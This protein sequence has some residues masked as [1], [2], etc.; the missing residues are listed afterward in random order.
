MFFKH[1]L[2]EKNLIKEDE[3]TKYHK[4]IFRET[5]YGRLIFEYHAHPYDPDKDYPSE[6]AIDYPDNR[7]LYACYIRNH[8]LLFYYIDR[9][10]WYT[11]KNNYLTVMIFAGIVG[12]K[13]MNREI[14]DE[15]S[16]NLS[17]CSIET[18]SYLLENHE[19]YGLSLQTAINSFASNFDYSMVLYL[20]SKGYT[21]QWTEAA[22]NMPTGHII[23]KK[24]IKF[25]EYTN[26]I[27]REISQ[28]IRPNGYC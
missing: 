6:P 12:L 21:V 26:R 18:I 24:G 2:Y 22:W 17:G 3:Q 5:F 28:G 9:S 11:L 10:E 23:S 27:S 13:M 4:E 25:R 7:I 16:L 14:T 15:A 19:K 8:K 20:I 1:K